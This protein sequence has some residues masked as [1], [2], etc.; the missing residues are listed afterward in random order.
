MAFT[1]SAFL[2][3]SDSAY[4]TTLVP[5]VRDALADDGAVAVAA[6]P[7]RIAVLRD[8]LGADARAVRFLPADEWYVRPVRTIAGWAHLLKTA[9]ASGRPVIH[10][11]GH[12]PFHAEQ[13]SWVRFEAAMNAALAPLTG[14]LLCPYDRRSLPPDVLRAAGRTHPRVHDGGWCAS[15][16]YEP[17]DRVLTELPEPAWPVSGEPVLT[18]TITDSV[19]ELR[20]EV[21]ER[22]R[23]EGW[24][25]IDRVESLVLAVSEIATNGIRHGGAQRAL[26]LWVAPEAVICEVTDD[27]AKPPAPLA[28]YLPPAPG[29]SGGM[30]LWLV[31]QLCD[32]MAIRQDN[33]VT[34]ARFA[35]R[36]A[37]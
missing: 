12:I 26:R 10:L 13:T 36:R 32:S 35:L 9:A 30:G 25:P 8:A 23:A 5:F 28:G 3:D 24:L 18:A 7:D 22:A 16:D 33:G 1:H 6:A 17:P 34:R 21:R 31:Q 2:Y 4:A 14:H 19:A 37:A 15:T 11:V 27:G 20:A 29:V